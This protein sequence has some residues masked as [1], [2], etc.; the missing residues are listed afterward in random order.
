MTDY[1]KTVLL[2]DDEQLMID[3]MKTQIDWKAHGFRVI[4]AAHNGKRALEYY[5]RFHPDLVVTDI[6]MPI[7]DGLELTRQIRMLSEETYIL[8]ITAYDEFEYA[9]KA[10]QSGVADYILKTGMIEESFYEK[11][12]EIREKLEIKNNYARRISDM[13]LQTFFNSPPSHIKYVTDSIIGELPN[14]RYIFFAISHHQPLTRST[15]RFSRTDIKESKEKRVW[16]GKLKI[17]D[18]IPAFVIFVNQYIVLGFATEKNIKLSEYRTRSM[19]RRLSQKLGGDSVFIFYYPLPMEL[20]E[21]HQVFYECNSILEF[22]IHFGDNL[23]MDIRE[24][25]ALNIRKTQN[26]FPYPPLNNPDETTSAEWTADLQIYLKKLFK[27][28]DFSGIDD[29]FKGFCYYCE[30]VLENN[31]LFADEIYVKDEEELYSWFLSEWQHC[32]KLYQVRRLSAY[33]PIVADTIALIR[34]KYGEAEMS[35]ELLAKNI[36]MSPGHLAQRF[37]QET[38]KTINEYLTD[39]RIESAAFLLENTN[40]KVYD[41]A[42]KIGY[43]SPQYFSQIFYKKTGQKPLD[44]R[45]KGLGNER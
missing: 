5:K 27:N 25:Q 4:A 40:D 11:L 20:F 24:L 10:L 44:L 33:S 41:I 28:Y 12:E 45:R 35:I 7:M 31:I 6:V 43:S 22:Y 32:M 17:S 14:G 9:K 36:G 15:A 1:A 21:F 29:L 8:I 16:Y 26:T 30:S 37:R 39:V 42:E 34:N 19:A 18:E 3:E 23:L 13:Q 38:G 2:V